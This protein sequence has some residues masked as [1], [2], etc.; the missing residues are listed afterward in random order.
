MTPIEVIGIILLIGVLTGGT[1]AGLDTEVAT[2][3]EV[4]LVC[5][6]MEQEAKTHQ[7]EE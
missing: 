7:L 1:V 6:S 4:C 2:K 5:V 3:T